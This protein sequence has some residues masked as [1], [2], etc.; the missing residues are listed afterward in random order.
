MYVCMYVYIYIYIYRV[1]KKTLVL[2][3]ATCKLNPQ[4]TLNLSTPR[5]RQGSPVS[6]VPAVDELPRPQSFDGGDFGCLLWG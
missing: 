1:L 6:P 4:T 2:F 5:V 3:G